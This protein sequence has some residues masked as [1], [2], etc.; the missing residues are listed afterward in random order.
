M[1]TTVAYILISLVFRG[2]EADGFIDLGFFIDMHQTSVCRQ[3]NRRW[4]G[5]FEKNID[6]VEYQKGRIT[7]VFETFFL[8]S[9]RE[10]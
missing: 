7:I 1:R 2:V 8:E 3:S 10:S 6:R 4:E 5:R 9:H